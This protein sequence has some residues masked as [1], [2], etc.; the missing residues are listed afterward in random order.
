MDKESNLPAA[1]AV[2][3]GE[4]GFGEQVLLVDESNNSEGVPKIEN[5]EVDNNYKED[6][7]QEVSSEMATDEAVTIDL[8]G[9]FYEA[10][11]G[12]FNYGLGCTPSMDGKKRGRPEEEKDESLEAVRKPY[13]K[14]FKKLS[15]KLGI[16]QRSDARTATIARHAKKIPDA[17]L[18]YIGS[19][20]QYKSQDIRKV[21]RSY[22]KAFFK[23]FI[24]VFKLEDYPE[25]G[26]LFIE[27]ILLCF[28]ETKVREILELLKAQSFESFYNCFSFKEQLKIR[29]GASQKSFKVLYLTN[30]CFKL[31]CDTIIENLPTVKRQ[32]R[33]VLRKIF[34]SIATHC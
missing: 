33:V 3:L 16:G 6:T 29:K 9:Q 8:A 32:E 34:S 4:K 30:N 1:P 2:L 22:L 7:F 25:K 5:S 24:P 28:P 31:V 21:M 17:F 26:T 13:K 27:F 20:S 15:N 11:R 14:W 23:C 10:S 18:K 12:N 19:K